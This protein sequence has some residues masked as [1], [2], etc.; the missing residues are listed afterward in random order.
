MAK[1]PDNLKRVI[2]GPGEEDI[3]KGTKKGLQKS[4]R[5]GKGKGER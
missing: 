5:K 2:A 4:R 3:F 1:L